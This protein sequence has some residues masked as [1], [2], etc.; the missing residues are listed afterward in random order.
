MPHRLPIAPP[1][2]SHPEG[3]GRRPGVPLPAETL[4]GQDKIVE[5]DKQSDPAAVPRYPGRPPAGAAAQRGAQASER[6]IPAFHEG[7][8]NRLAQAPL[9][10]LPEEPAGSP[11]DHPPD[12]LPQGAGGIAD[13]HDLPIEQVG[14]G[15]QDRLRLASAGPAPAAMPYA[16]Q[17][18]PQSPDIGFPAIAQPP[19]GGPGG[20]RRPGQSGGPPSPGGEAQSGPRARTGSPWPGPYAPIRHGSPGGSR[21]SHP[22]AHPQPSGPVRLARDAP[23]PAGRRPSGTGDGFDVHPPDIGGAGITD[24]PALTLQEACDRLFRQLGRFQQGAAPLRELL[25]TGGAP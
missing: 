17:D 19:Q 24:P 12:D 16:S 11:K 3:H 18:L 9:S 25:A 13:L 1:M 6:P 8:L 4:M 15:H 21:A 22:R 10:Q 14:G 20:G 23:A 2:V 7:G 5:I